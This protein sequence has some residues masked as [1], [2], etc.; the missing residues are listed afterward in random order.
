[1]KTNLKPYDYVVTAILLRA[2][3]RLGAAIELTSDGGDSGFEQGRDLI[4]RTFGSGE[5]A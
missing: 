3:A 4:R 5:P 2:K 1:V